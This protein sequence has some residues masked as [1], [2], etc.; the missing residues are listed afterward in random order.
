MRKY[1][2]SN[3]GAKLIT[4]DKGVA[5]WELDLK[6]EYGIKPVQAFSMLPPLLGLGLGGSSIDK[7]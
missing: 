4:D 7:K 1:I 2:K 5:W 3:Y 6:P